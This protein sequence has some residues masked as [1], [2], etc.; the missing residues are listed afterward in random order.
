MIREGYGK[1]LGRPGLALWRRECCIVALL[2]VLG[3]GPQ[4]RS[5][6][7]GAL[8]TGAHPTLVDGVL[9]AV[10]PRIPDDRR[11]TVRRV[12]QEVLARWEER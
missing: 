11:E 8:R 4:L 12:W 9:Q 10:R 1:V 6:L 2:A 3:V 5:H 7:R